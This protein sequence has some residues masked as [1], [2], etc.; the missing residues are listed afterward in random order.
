MILVRSE[1]TPDDIHGIVAAQ[2]TVTSRGGMTSH[3]AVVARG[4]GK[5]CI[6]GCETLN[7]DLKCKQFKVGDTIV[8]QGDM[9]TI[10][11]STGEVMLGE[12]P[13]IEPQLSDEFQLL[14][15]W[16]DQERKLDVRANADNPEDAKKSA[17][18]WGRWNWIM[19]Y[20]A[21]VYGCNSNPDCAR[22]DPCG[23]I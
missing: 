1:T 7:I 4:M 10:D 2:A 14:L 17:R 13:M 3:A 19:P 22:Y 16:A 12:V 18:V 8:R 11:G 21:Y 9:I 5:A 20:R 6:C 15:A 23:N